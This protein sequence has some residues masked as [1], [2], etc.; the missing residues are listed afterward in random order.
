VVVVPPW[1]GQGPGRGQRAVG[2]RV[3]SDRRPSWR[4]TRSPAPPPAPLARPSAVPSIEVE[5]Q[6]L[7]ATVRL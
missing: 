4:V 5:Q 3:Q 6:G 2:A 7:F 1:H